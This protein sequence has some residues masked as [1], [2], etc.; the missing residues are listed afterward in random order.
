V[1]HHEA[2]ETG[3]V[4]RELSDAVENAVDDLLADRVVATSVVVRGVFLKATSFGKRKIENITLPVMS[5]SGWKSC[6]YVPVRIWS[7]T[8]DSR[9]MKTERGT[10][11]PVPVSEKNVEKFS[12]FIPSGTVPSGLMPCSRQYSSQQE[13]P[14]WQPA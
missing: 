6:L 12:L 10:Y 8:D 11:W 9:S 3:A 5:C 14:I 2:L 13:M 7:I 1:E 4:V